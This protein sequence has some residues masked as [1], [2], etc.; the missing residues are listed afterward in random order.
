MKGRTPHNLNRTTRKLWK[1]LLGQ[2]GPWW[3]IAPPCCRKTRTALSARGL[4]E[5]TEGSTVVI[6][7]L[8]PAGVRLRDYWA[9]LDAH[10]A[11]KL[12]GG[13]D[14]PRTKRRH[15]V[16]SDSHQ[17]Q[18]KHGEQAKDPGHNQRG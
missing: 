9:K 13:G 2:M 1:S 8:T 10:A 7:R 17:P 5:F 3:Y 15:R 6:G 16:D 18:G 14:I 11:W 4:A 12:S